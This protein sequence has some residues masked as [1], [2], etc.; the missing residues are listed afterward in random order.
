MKDLCTDFVL[1]ATKRSAQAIGRSMRFMMFLH[2][3]LWL[4][5]AALKDLDRKALLN[6]P[7]TPSSLFSDVQKPRCSFQPPSSSL[8]SLAPLCAQD[9]VLV[10]KVLSLP[11]SSTWIL[12]LLGSSLLKLLC[13]LPLLRLSALEIC[14]LSVNA[15][16][17]VPGDCC[18]TL[19]PRPGFVPKSLSTPFK[20]QVIS[21]PALSSESSTSHDSD[22][23]GT[24]CPIRALQSYL[25]LLDLLHVVFGISSA[26]G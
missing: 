1:M 8:S 20:A 4:T 15:D 21:L 12:L 19:W 6:A 26:F 25:E 2:R 7:I 9:L 14:R 18:V 13:F 23:Q 22:A 11:R 24:V 16:C 17:F 3:H 5:L 10:L